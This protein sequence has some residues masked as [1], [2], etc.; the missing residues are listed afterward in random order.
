[1]V[2]R[3][4]RPICRKNCVASDRACTRV[5]PRNLH[6]MEGVD[7]SSPSEGLHKSPANRAMVL[8]AVAR[9]RVAAGTRRVHF[10]TGVHTRARATSR[11]TAEAVVNG[12]DRDHQ[13]GKCLQGRVRRCPR[14]R[15]YDHLPWLERR[16]PLRPAAHDRRWRAGQRGPS[17]FAGCPPVENAA[18]AAVNTVRKVLVS[19]SLSAVLGAWLGAKRAGEQQAGN[20][21]KRYVDKLAAQVGPACFARPDRPEGRASRPHHP[22]GPVYEQE[23]RDKTDLR[24]GGPTSSTARATL[25]SSSPSN[26]IAATSQEATRSLALSGRSSSRSET[27][28]ETKGT[29]EKST[30]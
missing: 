22:A 2:L 3:R 14:W 17:G 16:S 10:G 28:N 25:S 11:D 5:T 13:L 1:M 12:L 30:R 15:K 21:H 27:T 24:G 19:V 8:P 9:F 29:R 6:G 26:G 23:Q 4:I 7:G 20:E 18:V